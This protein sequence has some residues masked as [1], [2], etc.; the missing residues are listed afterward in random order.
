VEASEPQIEFT[1]G[2]SFEDVDLFGDNDE[3]KADTDEL[4]IDGFQ[5]LFPLDDTDG[6]NYNEGDRFTPF[7]ER[8]RVV[9][10]DLDKPGSYVLVARGGRGG[11]GN[12]YFASRHGPMPDGGELVG[13]AAPKPGEVAYLELEL[14]LIADLGLVGYPNAGSCAQDQRLG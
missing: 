13:R 8:K 10:A 5:P 1:D 2:D 7:S 11:Y 9:L 3:S 4:F 14:K 6:D 12:H